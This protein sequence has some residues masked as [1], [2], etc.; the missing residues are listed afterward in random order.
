MRALSPLERQACDV[1]SACASFP[2]PLFGFGYYTESAARA[3]GYDMDAARLAEQALDAEAA[4]SMF[5]ARLWYADGE[6]RIRSG[7]R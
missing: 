6:A 1:L 5:D 7:W 3:L 2:E 4:C